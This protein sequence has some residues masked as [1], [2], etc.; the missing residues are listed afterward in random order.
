[1]KFVLKLK[2]D[3]YAESLDHEYGQTTVQME[4]PSIGILGIIQIKH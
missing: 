2:E 3:L 4:Q 1:M